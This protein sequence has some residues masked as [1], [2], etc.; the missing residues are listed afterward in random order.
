VTISE[1]VLG[2]KKVS[3]NAKVVE[4]GDPHEVHS[5]F[6]DEP[7]VVC[8]LV[9]ADESGTIK[10]TLWEEEINKVNLNDNVQ[11]E[12]GYVTAW[13]KE[14]QLNVGKFGKLTVTKI[15]VTTKLPVKPISQQTPVNPHKTLLSE[16]KD[17]F[18][19]ELQEK[20][21]FEQHAQTVI[22]KPVKFLGSDNF[23]KALKIVLD[24]GGEYVSAGRDSHFRVQLKESV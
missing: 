9:L 10:L 16:V 11:I 7:Y 4:K 5:K 24:I 12:N 14:L 21:N 2:Q 20:L 19:T 23:A 8:D 18:P 17:A 3:L 13:K 6:R 22:I 15:P 1:L